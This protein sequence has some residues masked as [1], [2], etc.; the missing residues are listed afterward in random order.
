[1]CAKKS[2][3][4][5]SGLI[6]A[7]SLP[8]PSLPS[9]LS[10]P[11]VPLSL[12]RKMRKG[13]NEIRFNKNFSQWFWFRTRQS[14]FSRIFQNLQ[15]CIHLK[16]VECPS[17]SRILL[18]PNSPTN[19]ALCATSPKQARDPTKLKRKLEPNFRRYF[20]AKGEIFDMS[21]VDA[22]HRE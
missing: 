5:N 20:F 12:P 16:C 10:Q 3:R 17:P 8:P 2:C 21:D 22:L 11:K 13:R 19:L 18:S 4:R 14:N 7:P 15:F 6:A 1:M 9:L